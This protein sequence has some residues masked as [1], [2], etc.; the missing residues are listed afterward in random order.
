MRVLVLGGAA[1]G[2]A[3]VS[4]AADLPGVAEIVIADPDLGTAERVADRIAD[5]RR[6][7]CAHGV[8]LT[9]RD[10]LL[11]ALR[12]ADVVLDTVGPHRECGLTV[13]RAAIE[14][15]THYLDACDE[16]ES[17]LRRGELEVEARA[18][19]VCAIAG[20][21]ARLGIGSLLALTAARE[22]GCVRDVFVASTGAHALRT[23]RIGGTV[24]SREDG[25]LVTSSMR[26]VQA[27]PASV[28]FESSTTPPPFFGVAA[29]AN[30]ERGEAVLARL[31]I[32]LE[33]SL[34]T[35]D[36]ATAT[37]TS[38][39]LG[40]YQLLDDAVRRPGV[41]LA[42][43]II[44]PELFFRDLERVHRLVTTCASIRIERDCGAR[45]RRH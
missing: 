33:D 12:A 31:S 11:G 10:H 20:M 13:L 24:L 30:P 34:L 18:A 36:T 42:G 37:G 43:A 32:P 38:L 9:D 21:G 1:A 7:I 40:L 23:G 35:I 44:D 26:G 29:G 22:L 45:I 27:S 4:T 3:A 2:E 39:A 41:H 28:V 25:R 14:T 8:E 5:R 16:W 15:G 6:P 19:G 17:T